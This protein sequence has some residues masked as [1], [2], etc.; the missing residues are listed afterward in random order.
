MTN[1]P[2]RCRTSIIRSSA[3]VQA[4]SSLFMVR[5]FCAASCTIHQYLLDEGDVAHTVQAHVSSGIEKTG[6]CSS[7]VSATL[8]SCV[9]PIGDS[10]LGCPVAFKIQNYACINFVW[11][12]W[13]ARAEVRWLELKSVGNRVQGVWLGSRL[14]TVWPWTRRTRHPMASWST[15]DHR[16]GSLPYPTFHKLALQPL[17]LC[18]RVPHICPSA[19]RLLGWCQR[20]VASLFSY[21]LFPYIRNSLCRLVVWF[22][23][24]A[25]SLRADISFRSIW[26]LE[27][28]GECDLPS[29]SVALHLLQS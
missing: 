18:K 8:V 5:T 12:Y 20:R 23:L 15:Y 6:F 25:S 27:S 16:C 4:S 26:H 19:H 22:V 21:R 11:R 24:V 17:C 29:R 3:L 1:S 10:M 2:L 28:W 14:H 9:L 13:C 7:I